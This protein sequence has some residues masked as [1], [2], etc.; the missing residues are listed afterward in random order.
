MKRAIGWLVSWSLYLLGDA[1]SRPMYRWDM[2]AWL[3]PA[4][5]NLMSWSVDVKDWGG[6]GP[7]ERVE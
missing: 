4:Y 5:N 1:I 2:F 3:Y 7:W 6:S